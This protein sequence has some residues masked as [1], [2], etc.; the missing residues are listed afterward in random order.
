MRL[1]ITNRHR[2]IFAASLLIFLGI[3]AQEIAAEEVKTLEIGSPAPDFNLPA[4]DGRSYKLSDFA[5]APILTVVFTCNHCPTAQAYERRIQALA[6]DYRGRGMALVA[7]SPNDPKAVRLDELGYTDLSD[8]LEEM[9]I[10]AKDRK[11]TFPYLYDGDEQTATH[12]YGPTTTPHVFV[13]DK[14][15]KLRYAGRV[16]DSEKP[17]KVGSSD[18]RNAIEALLAGRPVPVEK[19][20]TFGCSIKW[21]DKR[22]SVKSGFDRWANEPVSLET[23]D[24][25]G[26]QALVRND[27]KKVRLINVWAT[28]CGPCVVEFP[29]LITVHRMYRGRDFELITI[30]A[31]APENKEAAL[32]F[33]KKQQASTR[34]YIFSIENK[35]KLVDAVDKD[36]P[37]S[38]PYTILVEP[39]GK[40]IYRVLGELSPL[41]L[42]KAVVERV[43]RYYP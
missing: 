23:I 31:D 28:W 11:F 3:C 26:I 7:I 33:L 22:A 16:D 8:S 36:W 39:G 43:G 40:I 42:K 1:A 10:R 30:S 13:F 24:E 41:D 27:S 34:N 4:V 38:L 17:D 5:K 25:K 15:R 37:G 29:E 6:D 20:K 19:T 12:A 18:A 21:A 35:Y 14:E 9:K 2:R 32:A